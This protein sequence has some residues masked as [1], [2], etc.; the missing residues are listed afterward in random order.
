MQCDFANTSS[1]RFLMQMD[2]M[3]TAKTLFSVLLSRPGR[4]GNNGSTQNSRAG[5][6]LTSFAQ[7][8]IHVYRIAAEINAT[9]I[10]GT[11]FCIDLIILN[12]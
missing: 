6:V 3:K 1:L 9:A 12:C 10:P 5:Q 2:R 4:A 8:H 7:V 11:A